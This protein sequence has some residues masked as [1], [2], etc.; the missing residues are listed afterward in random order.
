MLLTAGVEQV[1]FYLSGVRKLRTLMRE[2]RS[3]VG[4]INIVGR[5]IRRSNERNELS[6][7]ARATTNPDIDRAAQKGTSPFVCVL[8]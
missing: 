7:S 6:V 1:F 3:P 8:Y 4:D 2:K 5:P